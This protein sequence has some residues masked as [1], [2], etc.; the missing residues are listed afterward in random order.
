MATLEL[1]SIKK[2]M[3]RSLTT[4]QKTKLGLDHLKTSIESWRIW[5]S[6]AMQDILVRYRGS[7]L[8]PFWITISTAITA[9]SMG[10]LYGILFGID[11]S[12]YL[13]YFTTGMITWT[14]ISMIINES[15]KILLESKPYM[16]NIQLPCLVYIFR[17]VLRNLIIFAHNLPVYISVALIYHMQIDMNI[18]LLV[19]GLL[20]LCLNSIFYGTIIAFV[21]TRYPDVGSIVSSIL[22]VLFFITPI[23]WS[24]ANLP[25]KFHLYLALNPFYYYVTLLRNPLLGLSYTTGDL[26]GVGILTLVGFALFAPIV[27]IYSKRVIFWL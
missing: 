20:L 2:L 16:E 13:P 11:R 8:G 15:T 21:S 17:M 19:P 27:K 6:L 25:A 5:S 4:K 1:N 12:T 9:Y 3:D 24:P 18:F 23:M 10:F 22:Q 14:F 7:I 26:I